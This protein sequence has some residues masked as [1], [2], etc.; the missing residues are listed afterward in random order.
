MTDLVPFFPA[1]VMKC[2]SCH[3]PLSQPARGRRRRYCG[4]SCRQRAYRQRRAVTVAVMRQCGM[5]EY[6]PM[7]WADYRKPHPW[8]NIDKIEKWIR[9]FWGA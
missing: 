8:E 1:C 9:C 7:K 3:R 2:P 6:V 5:G 4:Q